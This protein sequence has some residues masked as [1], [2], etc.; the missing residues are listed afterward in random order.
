MNTSRSKRS[1]F[2]LEASVIQAQRLINSGD[3]WKFEGSVGRQTMYEITV[4]NLMLGHNS[5]GDYWGNI[6]PSRHHVKAGTKG[7]REHV[8]EANGEDYAAALEAIE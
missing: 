1:K 3:I 4:G 7:S 8:A 6:V 5:R 2:E